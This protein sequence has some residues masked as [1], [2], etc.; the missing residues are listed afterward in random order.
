MRKLMSSVVLLAMFGVFA[1]GGDVG[2]CQEVTGDRFNCKDGWTEAEC[3]DWD[4]Q[5]I[6][7][8][9]WAFY[10]GQSCSDR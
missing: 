6:N 1:C 5:R 10:E 4:Q 2:A 9:R 7:G 3:D 8:N